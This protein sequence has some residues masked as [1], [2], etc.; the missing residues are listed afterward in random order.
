LVGGG[1]G[2]AYDS[3]ALYAVNAPLAVIDRCH[4]GGGAYEINAQNEGPIL[5]PHVSEKTAI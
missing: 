1:V 3:G 5:K 2:G 4:H